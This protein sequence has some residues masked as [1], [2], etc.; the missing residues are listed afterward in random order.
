MHCTTTGRKYSVVYVIY[1]TIVVQNY[2]L[3]I[4]GLGEKRAK[5]VDFTSNSVDIHSWRM[6]L[7]S[8]PSVR[9]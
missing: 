7:G 8:T 4:A 6:N 9:K 3:H 5:L 1:S 2:V